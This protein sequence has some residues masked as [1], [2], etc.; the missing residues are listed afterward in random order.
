MQ[1][2]GNCTLCC[3]FPKI[4]TYNSTQGEYCEHCTP[5]VGCNIYESRPDECRLFLCAYAQMKVVKPEM[6]P[7]KCGMMFE[8]IGDKIIIG[9]TDGSITRL[10]PL[11]KKQVESF[12]KEGFTVVLQKF[13]PFKF[14]GMLAKGANKQEVLKALED[15]AR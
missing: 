13:N 2:C 14:L 3:K 11:L 5:G 8:K 1:D 7:D 6:R 12:G 4:V 9:S 10:S 15:K